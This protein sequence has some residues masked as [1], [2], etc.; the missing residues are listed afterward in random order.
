MKTTQFAEMLRKLI[1]EEVRSV[2]REE[3]KTALTPVLLEQRKMLSKPLQQTK[4]SLATNNR[5]ASSDLGFSMKGPLGDI[6]R[7]TANE[8]R[9]GNSAHIQESGASDWA[10]MGSMYTAN[11]AAAFGV[12]HDSG[13]DLPNTS[14]FDNSTAPF[15]KDYSAVLKSSYEHSGI[16]G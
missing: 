13:D 12:M 5:K 9:N 11:D 10:D 14:H 1:R 15:M 7:E 3:I 4:P 2:V 8:L 6:L 16:K